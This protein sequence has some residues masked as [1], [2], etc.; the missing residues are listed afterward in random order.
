M[1]KWWKFF[2]IVF[3][4]RGGIALLFQCHV[5][6]TRVERCFVILNVF[7]GGIHFVMVGMLSSSYRLGG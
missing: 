6:L 4:K 7:L 1:Y 2:S 3:Q 5:T